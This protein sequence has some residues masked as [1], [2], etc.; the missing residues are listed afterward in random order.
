MNVRPARTH[1]RAPC[2]PSDASVGL[3]CTG[4]FQ[5]FFSF[6][7]RNVCFYVLCKVWRFFSL[8]NDNVF[9]KIVKRKVTE[10]LIIKLTPVK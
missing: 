10:C 2:W 3:L 6:L 1:A 7:I 9:L 4:S 8:E 5:L